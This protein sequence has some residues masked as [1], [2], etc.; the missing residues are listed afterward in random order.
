M[1]V[2][3]SRYSD[4]HIL[5]MINNNKL[6]NRQLMNLAAKYGNLDKMKKF[7]SISYQPWGEIPK[8]STVFIKAV[9]KGYLHIMQWL[10]SVNCPYSGSVHPNDWDERTFAHAIKNGNLENIKWLKYVGCPWGPLTFENAVKNRNFIIMKF[11]KDNGCP[12]DAHTSDYAIGRE[13]EEIVE[14]LKENDCPQPKYGPGLWPPYSANR[15]W[16][17]DWYLLEIKY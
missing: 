3:I 16:E 12:W 2:Y 8:D 10:R 9:R 6:D 1:K 13:D 15:Q 17:W 11:L 14:W 4:T 5:I 7:Y